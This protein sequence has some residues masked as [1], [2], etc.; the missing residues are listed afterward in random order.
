MNRNL[1]DIDGVN[2]IYITLSEDNLE[3]LYE[4]VFYGD[5]VFCWYEEGGEIYPGTIKVRGDFSRQT[6]KKSFT[7]T[8]EKPDKILRYSFDGSYFD[9]SALRN[10]IALNTYNALGLPVPETTGTALFINGH[11]LGYYTRL[12]LYTEDKLTAFYHSASIELYNCKFVNMGSDIPLQSLSEKKIPEDD[13]FSSLNHLLIQA[14]T[15]T[16]DEWNPWVAENFDIDTTA[17]Y[18]VVLNYLAVTDTGTKNF[19]IALMDGKYF[20]LPWDNEA[21]MRRNHLGHYTVSNLY[22][23]DGSNILSMRL[24]SE[25]CPVKNRYNELLNT[26]FLSDTAFREQIRNMITTYY[27]EIDS[28]VYYD[29][30]R[31]TDYQSFLDEYSFLMCF[32]DERASE[33]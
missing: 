7:I 5:K 4:S 6:D 16:N 21:C 10:R 25:G 12:N 26:L 28:A 20:Y 22:N 8:V 30:N 17:R 9:P 2:N 24:L 31:H 33:F 23:V 1:S 15:L 32:L 18:L 11:Y 27:E 14:M 19:Y 13:D 29:P 3:R